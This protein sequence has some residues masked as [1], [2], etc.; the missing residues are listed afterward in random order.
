M[1]IH[2]TVLKLLFPYVWKK[3]FSEPKMRFF[4]GGKSYRLILDLE[5]YIFGFRIYFCE[6]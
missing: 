6:T 1:H 3:L 2:L 4:F 5:V